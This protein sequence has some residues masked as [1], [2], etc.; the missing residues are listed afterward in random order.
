MQRN[1]SHEIDKHS[2]AF[3]DYYKCAL[4]EALKKLL[5]NTGS[6]TFNYNN[7]EKHVNIFSDN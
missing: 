7:G 5:R 1:T 2:N 4:T 3:T 6:E